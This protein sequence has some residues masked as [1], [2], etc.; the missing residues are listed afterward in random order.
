M[1]FVVDMCLV[2][3]TRPRG[4]GLMSAPAR[5]AGASIDNARMERLIEAVAQERSREAFAELFRVFAPRLKAY[6]MRAGADAA[7]AEELAQE[8]MIAVWRK[9]ASF[10]PSKASVSTWMFTIA[11]NKRIDFLRREARPDLR[12]EDFLHLGQDS[13]D[14]E[15]CLSGDQQARAAKRVLATLPA[16]QGEAIRMAYFEDRSH[17]DIAVALDLPLGTVKSRIR[18]ALARLREAMAE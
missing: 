10:D 5:P 15:A 17:R 6:G 1:A 3:S 13:A 2:E 12:E 11:R 8:A 9:A 16:E 14:T 4:I 7:I 18:L